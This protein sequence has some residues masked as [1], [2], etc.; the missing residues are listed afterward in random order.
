MGCAVLSLV[1]GPLR[2]AIGLANGLRLMH[3]GYSNRQRPDGAGAR[4]TVPY[5]HLFDLL[6]G[7]WNHVSSSP[8]SRSVSWQR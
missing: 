7:S 5:W 1:P 6:E 2:S 4:I 3:F 8:E